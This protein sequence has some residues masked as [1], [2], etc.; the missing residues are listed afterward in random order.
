MALKMRKA[1]I[2]H[3]IRYSLAYIQQTTPMGDDD[4]DDNAFSLKHKTTDF[5]SSPKNNQKSRP[6]N[7]G[8]TFTATPTR[9]GMFNSVQSNFLICY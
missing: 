6:K 3:T 4:D 5:A 2:R 1:N 8:S 7:S 9:S